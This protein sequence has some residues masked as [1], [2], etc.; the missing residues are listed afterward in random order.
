MKRRVIVACVLLAGFLLLGTVP[1]AAQSN[2]SLR[3]VEIPNPL[4]IGLT[5]YNQ[6]QPYEIESLEVE[7]PGLDPSLLEGFDVE[8]E[9][10]STHLRLDYWVL[11]FLNVFGLVGQIETKT[12]VDLGG[13]DIGL[14]VEINDLV[15]DTEGT[16]YGLGLVLAVGGEKWFAT[17]AYDYTET[18]LDVA[19]SSVSASVITPKVGLRLKRGAV[20]VGT[21]YQRAEEE[22]RGTFDL[23]FVGPVPFH[24]KL[25]E[26]ESWNYQ[27][28]ATAGLSEHWVLI[29]QGGFGKRQSAL[30]TI[31]YRF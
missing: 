9:T 28:G 11:P 16:V 18:D 29:L 5:F 14:P 17:L 13:L 24:V 30:A 12:T 15:V 3:G 25:R 27:I 10:L 26:K 6:T 2:R 19:T 21:M 20:W 1:A 7:F 4:G 31:E 23:P 8:N 22:H